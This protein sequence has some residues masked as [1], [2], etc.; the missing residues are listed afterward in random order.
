MLLVRYCKRIPEIAVKR[1]AI[2]NDFWASK[3]LNN[4][5]GSNNGNGKGSTGKKNNEDAD[6]KAAPNGL[7]K[8]ISALQKALSVVII[9]FG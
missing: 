6:S 1:K 9:F 5:K 3:N 8:N 4:R 2:S 7:S